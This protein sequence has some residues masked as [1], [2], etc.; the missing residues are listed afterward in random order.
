[1]IVSIG[2]HKTSDDRYYDKENC[3]VFYSKLDPVAWTEW[4]INRNELGELPENYATIW[5]TTDKIP[6]Y[7]NNDPTVYVFVLVTDSTE[8]TAQYAV[9]QLLIMDGGVDQYVDRSNTARENPVGIFLKTKHFDGGN[10]FRLKQAKMGIVEVFGSDAEHRFSTS[11]D[12]DYT[13]DADTEI[14]GREFQDFTVGNASNYVKFPGMFPFRRAALNFRAELQAADSQI[15]LK[16]V[17]LVQDTLSD[18]A[19]QVA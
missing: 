15:K 4:N 13:V 17:A 19:E 9:G 2:K 1:M 10:P 7:L 6:T 16:Q 12:I 18:V 11:W 3:R 8:T 14:E 5:S